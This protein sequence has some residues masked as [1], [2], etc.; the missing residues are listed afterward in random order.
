MKPKIQDSLPDETL[1]R[2]PFHRP[3]AVSQIIPLLILLLFK[4]LI[5]DAS[6]KRS[7]DCMPEKNLSMGPRNIC[8]VLCMDKSD[9]VF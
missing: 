6:G 9:V 7:V 4:I 8:I 2:S 5:T 1:A 3:P